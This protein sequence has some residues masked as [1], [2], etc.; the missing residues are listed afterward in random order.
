MYKPER[1]FF[2]FRI[3]IWALKMETFFPLLA[4]VGAFFC[5]FFVKIGWYL[6][7]NG[8]GKKHNQLNSLKYQK[9]E[10]SGLDFALF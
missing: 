2:V 8:Y 7:L 1:S 9:K 3:T 4:A 5:C 10:G 6:T